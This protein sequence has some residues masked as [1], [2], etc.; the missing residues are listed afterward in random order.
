MS[1]PHDN[2]PP[3]QFANEPDWFRLNGHMDTNMH[4]VTESKIKQM[5]KTKAGIYEDNM[6]KSELRK[7]QIK[8]NK[9]TDYMAGVLDYID[10]LERQKPT[11]SKEKEI[12]ADIILDLKEILGEYLNETHN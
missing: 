8:L 9:L 4:K 6:F 5:P 10:Y 11:N 7:T 1:H 2:Y 3:K 12:Y